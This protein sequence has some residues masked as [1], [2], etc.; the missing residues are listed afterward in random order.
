MFRVKLDLPEWK[1]DEDVARHLLKLVCKCCKIYVCVLI[2][3]LFLQ[4][5]CVRSFK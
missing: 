5:P 1:T 2:I 4:R 3:M